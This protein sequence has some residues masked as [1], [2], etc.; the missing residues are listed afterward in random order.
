MRRALLV[1]VAACGTPAD[2]KLPGASITPHLE[3]VVTSAACGDDVSYDGDSATDISYTYDYD[4]LGRLVH[5]TG[6]Y[7]AG[8]DDSIDYSYDYLDHAT[9]TIETRAWGNMRIEVSSDYD[10]LGDLIEYTWAG[11]GYNDNYHYVFSAFND[12]G[13]P[14][15]ELISQFGQPPVSDQLDYDPSGR[16]MVIVQ[17]DGSTTTYTYDDSDTRTITIDTDNGAFHGVIVYDDQDHELSESWDGTDPGLIAEDSRY[18]W[19]GNRLLTETYR[20][21]STGAPHQLTTFELDTLRYDCPSARRT[22]RLPHPRP[23]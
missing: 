10:T 5:A 19:S 18:E 12:A 6:V 16:I 22:T 1:A 7:A 15:R 11:G 8:P 17:N 3:A 9:H 14:T 13:A 23:R 20:S 2:H 4:T 21:G